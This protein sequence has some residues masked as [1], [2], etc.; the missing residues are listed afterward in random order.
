VEIAGVPVIFLRWQVMNDRC[1]GH[2]VR[3]ATTRSQSICTCELN[4]IL[5]SGL[6]SSATH[7]IFRRRRARSELS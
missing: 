6:T 3:I 5:R 4:W 7:P 1:D 2:R